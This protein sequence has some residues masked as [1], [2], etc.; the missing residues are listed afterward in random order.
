MTDGVATHQVGGEARTR[1][2]RRWL[3]LLCAVLALGIL[4]PACSKK[5]RDIA[6]P[7]AGP[8]I[9]QVTPEIGDTAGGEAVTIYT[10]GFRDDFTLATPKVFFG[11]DLATVTSV[12]S[13]TLT[14]VT[15]AHPVP[16]AVDVRLFSTGIAESA[17]LPS[18][19][20]YLAPAGCSICYIFSTWSL[21][22]G[23]DV[24]I[25]GE[26]TP[27]PLPLTEVWFGAN[28]GT[29]I[30]ADAD[31]IV[32][33]APPGTVGP[34]DVTVRDAGGRTCV[35]AGCY[36]YENTGCIITSV[37]GLQGG[38]NGGAAVRIGGWDYDTQGV[39]VLFGG[40][41]ADPSMIVVEPAGD[42]IRCV[43]PPSATGGIKPVEVRGLTN[44]L[45]CIVAGTFAYLLPGGSPCSIASID[46]GSG[47]AG[48]GQTVTITGSGFDLNAGVLFGM[49][50]ATSVTF[51]N[52]TT[53]EVVTP[54]DGGMM[55]P[56]VDV[57]V[58]PEF[59]DPCVVPKGYT[60][61]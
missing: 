57:V 43:A 27:G 46:P 14:A 38:T 58:A 36:S 53:I 21:L 39:E 34:V 11:S 29:V 8:R 48:V 5:R 59:S 45:N 1:V 18:G 25:L 13:S 60:Y 17:T 35:C 9:T 19:Y 51:V 3:R 42:T 55:C 2:G 20:T 22:Q 40:A 16:E 6:P 30:S 37:T 4:G 26:F 56:A 10:A 32:V 52:S 54:P 7:V 24:T 15:P 61:N 33:T 49:R 44:G 28:Q 12:N 50:P 41:Y 31:G 23:W 47:P